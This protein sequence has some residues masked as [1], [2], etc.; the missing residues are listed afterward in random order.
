LL[1]S[2]Q[3]FVSKA[4]H[5]LLSK[6]LSI[7]NEYFFTVDLIDIAC[8][9]YRAMYISHEERTRGMDENRHYN[10]DHASN[11]S[12]HC[13]VKQVNERLAE[14]GKRLAELRKTAGYTQQE[15]ADELGVSRRVIGYYESESQHPPANLL[16]EL[17]YALNISADE[18]LG[19]KQL[20]KSKQPDS[21]LLRRMQQ[22]EK[23]NTT[24]KRQ[25]LQIIDTF[26]EAEQ[27]KQKQ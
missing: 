9:D 20:K 10:T 1:D 2:G 8:H 6:I 13:M 12:Y 23:L 11:R 24:K 7:P 25:L 3:F 17:A 4:A 14:F 18:L 16:V 21:R 27:L 26:I 5:S 22:I 19:I 15:L